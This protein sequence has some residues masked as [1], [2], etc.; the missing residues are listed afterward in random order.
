MGE[1]V[2]R[3]AWDHSAGAHRT[4][5]GRSR[6]RPCIL[7]VLLLALLVV[8]VVAR[9]EGEIASAPS[10]SGHQR[11]MLL[12]WIVIA[13]YGMCMIAI[14]W[15][16]H[17]RT[18]TREDY[19]LGGRR[20]GFKAVGLSLFATM[21]STISYLALPGEMIKNGPM[22]LA[23]FAAYPLTVLVVGW[24]I[25]PRIVQF[26]VT[27]AYEILEVRLGLGV[28]LLGSFFF[29]SLRLLWMS[30]IIY[31]TATKIIVPLS[32]LSSSASPW[33]CVA[34]G[35]VTVLYTTMGGLRAVIL[36]DVIQTF[37]LFAGAIASLIVI[38]ISLG[39]V[40]AW[41][42]TSWAPTWQQ[43]NWF[44]PGARVSFLGAM[45]GPFFWYICT[46]GSDQMAVQRYLSTRNVKAARNALIVSTVTETIVTLFLA[47]MGFALLAY[48]VARPQVFGTA[49]NAIQHADELFP[50]FISIGLPVGVSGLVVAGLLA[51]AMSSLSSGVSASCS[52]VTVDLLE[53]LRGI[54]LNDK[55]NIRMARLVS[56]GVGIVTVA[57]SLYVSIVPGNLLEVCYRVVNLLVAPLFVL[58]AMAMF[59]PWATPFGTFVAAACSVAVAVS[60]A[61]GELIFGCTVASFLWIV[62][63]SLFAGVIAGMIA[64]LLP[65]GRAA[66]PITRQPLVD[67]EEMP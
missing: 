19:L 46:S 11:L 23:Q 9:A 17:R 61:Y 59:V 55:Q 5:G 65:V 38:T 20:M 1:S 22:I 29:L 41:W 66:V 58:F 18:E 25:I 50:M 15:Y 44:D 14:G 7:V 10:A 12:D 33:I 6:L 49:E 4:Q 34:I 8:P 42:P 35:M 63:G 32:G 62:P 16:Y 64:S 13:V 52:V 43:P 47:V 57:L 48:F 51:A 37:I 26:R 45:L 67:L 3:D 30:V 40:G 2:R 31:A 60:I 28:R 54:K 39:G 56:L 21:L 36:T 53:R 27:T 24:I